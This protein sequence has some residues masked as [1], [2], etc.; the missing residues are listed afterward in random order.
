MQNNHC[1]SKN[2]LSKSAGFDKQGCDFLGQ[3][4]DLA[5]NVGL[6][7]ENGENDSNLGVKRLNLAE[8]RPNSG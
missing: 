4:L 3:W 5:E 1:G 2:A 8:F 7:T 6:L